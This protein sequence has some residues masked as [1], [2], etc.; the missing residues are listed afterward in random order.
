MG[1][2]IMPADRLV[3]ALAYHLS[4]QHQHRTDR[5]LALL[6]RSLGKNQP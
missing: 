5:Y 2:G 4:I 3:P 1:G 6:L